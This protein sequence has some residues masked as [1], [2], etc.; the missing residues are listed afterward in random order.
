MTIRTSS[1]ILARES[2]KRLHSFDLTR[3]SDGA[4]HSCLVPFDDGHMIDLV[5]K[6][7]ML[8]KNVVEHL[9]VKTSV[10]RSGILTLEDVEFDIRH[11]CLRI[12]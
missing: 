12:C 11:E 4:K 5:L 6:P 3:V 8:L 2:W 10:V 1:T 7:G 9:L